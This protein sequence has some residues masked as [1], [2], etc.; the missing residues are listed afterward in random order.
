M[1]EKSLHIRNSTAEFLIFTAQAGTQ[2]IEVRVEDETV[3]LTQKMMAELFQIS[4]P[5]ISQHL[6]NILE[7]KELEEEAGL[8]RISGE[9]K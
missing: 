4:V 8:S 1:T 5:A 3:W 9:I 2:E 7:S 6:K